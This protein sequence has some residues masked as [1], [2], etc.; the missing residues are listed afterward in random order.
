MTGVHE[1]DQTRILGLNWEKAAEFEPR[2]AAATESE[3]VLLSWGPSRSAD[4]L[5]AAL[6]ATDPSTRVHRA[7]LAAAPDEI[8]GQRC[9]FFL[10]ETAPLT[11]SDLTGDEG[12]A[13]AH[14]AVRL[15][16]RVANAGARLWIVTRTGLHGPGAREAVRPEHDFAWALGR[17]HAAERPESW[18]GLVDLDVDDPTAAGRLLADYLL[19]DSAEDEVLLRD[20][21]PLVAR[22]RASALP[23]VASGQGLSPRRLHVVSGGAAGLSFEVQR[24]LARRGAER[25][26]VLGRSPLDR[27]RERNLRLL[28]NLGCAAE[29]EVL[30]VG[31]PA[32]VRALTNRLRARGDAIGGVFHLASN[33]RID[34]LSCV[35]SLMN[36]TEEQTRVLLSAKASGALLL[37]ELA[38]ELGAEAMVLFSSAAAT[39]G[40]PGQAGYAAANAVLDG[41]ARRLN[42]GRVRAVSIAWGPIGEVGFG[43]TP[44]GAQLHEVWERLGLRRLTVDQ[45][46]STVDMALARDE[47]NLAVASW[48]DSAAELLTWAGSRPVLEPLA[49]TQPV[50]LSLERLAEL[51]DAERVGYI[52]EVIREQLGQMLSCAPSDLDPALPLASMD[53]DSLIALEMLFVIEREFAVRLGLDELLL[54]MNNTLVAMAE[55]LDRRVRDDALAVS[56]TA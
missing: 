24:W 13:W 52:V 54:G 39:F 9:V 17:C 30:D 38:E 19:S 51:P 33:W 46:L 10:D 20:D 22:L 40:S 3:W 45:V 15:C 28:A 6:G 7:D 43:A 50:G 31:D 8:Q 35:S 23:P 11:G 55:L 25:L 1:D 47:P 18:G 27:D 2:P 48:D 49:A 34:G 16:Q 37:G 5:A 44:D 42:R 21:G 32:A 26:L 53:I 41:V 29:Y 14:A 4:A 56:G 12:W 36:S